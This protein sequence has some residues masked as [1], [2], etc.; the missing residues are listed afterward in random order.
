MQC[1]S[2]GHLN[3]EGRKFCSE[4]AAALEVRC[5]SCSTV[6]EP[7]EKYCGECA[8]PLTTNSRDEALARAGPGDNNKGWEAAMAAVQL[9]NVMQWLARQ[10]STGPDA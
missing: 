3:R 2:C 4:C 10:R 5:P 7:G 9:A 1:P 6:N 8:A